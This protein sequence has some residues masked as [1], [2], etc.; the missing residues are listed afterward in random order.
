MTDLFGTHKPMTDDHMM[1][2][3]VC[4][5]A[6]DKFTDRA[7]GQ[8][9]YNHTKYA[10]GAV[11]TPHEPDPIPVTQL[12]DA[13]MKCDFCNHLN[14]PWSY[15]AEN[16]AL[17]RN[18]VTHE[19]IGVVEHRNKGYAA[20]KELVVEKGKITQ[21]WGERWA[22]CDTCAGFIEAR[23]VLALVGHVVEGLPAKLTRGKRLIQTRSEL[24]DTYQHLLDTLKP[25]RGRITLDDPLPVWEA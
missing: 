9:T 24:L 19:K 4:K 18:T 8:A 12:P 23:D 21:F 16:Q 14:P 1:Y 11:T 22:A 10:D 17:R 3:R 15:I 25:G 13:I 6:L 20:K 5:L 2:C 7:T